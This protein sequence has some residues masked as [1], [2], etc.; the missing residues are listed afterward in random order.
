M[1]VRN[2]QEV[3][4]YV[5]VTAVETMYMKEFKIFNIKAITKDGLYIK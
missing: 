3:L 5:M 4:E 1:E 2:H